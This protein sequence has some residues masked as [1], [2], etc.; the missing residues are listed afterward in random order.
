MLP[1]CSY[2]DDALQLPGPGLWGTLAAGGV[3]HTGSLLGPTPVA[4]GAAE[5]TQWQQC[6]LSAGIP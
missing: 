4:S 2:L 3:S 5:G 1:R 6:L